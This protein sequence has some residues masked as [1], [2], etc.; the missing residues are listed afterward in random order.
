MYL[1]ST[2]GHYS[3]VSMSANAAFL[4]LTWTSWWVASVGLGWLLTG[5]RGLDVGKLG[6][7]GLFFVTALSMFVGLVLPLAA[8]VARTIAWLVLL[9][10]VVAF[11]WAQLWRR[12]QL[13]ILV[14]VVAVGA[15]LLSS[16]VPSNYDLGLYHAG[17]I[18]Y[19]REGG[20]VIG[21]ANL[22]DRFGFSS[23]MWPLSAFLGLGMWD[24]G[25]FRLVNGL[26]LLSLFADVLERV[27]TQRF[28]QPGTVVVTAGTV[29]LT[30]AAIQYP[31]RLIASS[32]QDWAV[33]VL[34]VVATAY[35]IDALMK[36]RRY[37]AT[38]AILVGAMAGAM[39][40]TGWIFTLVTAV[41]LVVFYARDSSW[42]RACVVVRWGVVGAL[43]LAV[44]TGVRD[45]LTSG[46][47]L[48]PAS[49]AP[50]PVA[51]RYPDPTGTS[52]DITAWARTPFQDS[53]QTL[54]DNTWIS[55]W[56]VRLTTDWAVVVVLV[57]S[58][59][60]ALWLTASA[61]GRGALISQWRI[62]LLALS[63]S[64]VVLIMW[65]VTAPDPRFAWG[66][67]L[68]M[69]LVPL[70]FLVPAAG[71]P[72]VWPVAV[73]FGSMAIVALAGMRGSLSDLS[74]GLQPMPVAQLEESLIGNNTPVSI[75]VDGD[76]CWSAFPLCRPSYSS[77][78]VE[79]RGETWRS[80]FQP[81]SRRNDSQ[82]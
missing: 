36:A 78:D 47:L 54:A 50:I 71:R 8:P 55:G 64:A 7:V 19:V 73:I 52:E 39:R 58:L 28:R 33:A 48:F 13:L 32:A 79:L 2:L 44:L 6:W 75:P 51:W 30:G 10:G 20:T 41:V 70:G 67:L 1:P 61:D 40:P 56:L 46:W 82:E 53:A 26:L 66:P 18:A 17:S 74:L 15:S 23:S 3:Q 29:L 14:A 9:T 37:A 11:V 49:F 27:G 22:H 63:P 21:L 4:A 60:L 45:T 69:A 34:L 16:V 80:G 5:R 25:E 43:G 77:T 81:M 68:L 31:G 59:A 72:L 38:V 42:R 12:W 35:L 65:F 76:Q 57:L 24:G 62:L